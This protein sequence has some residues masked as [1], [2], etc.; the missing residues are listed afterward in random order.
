MA[1]NGTHAKN[2]KNGNRSN[3]GR[4]VRLHPKNGKP[5][6]PAI[7]PS[8]VAIGEMVPQ[9][10]GG[11]L[12]RGGPNKGGTGRPPDAFR[13]L[14]RELASGEKTIESVIKILGD[15][16]HSQFVAALRWATEHGYGKAIQP[17]E[18]SG[19]ISLEQILAASHER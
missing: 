4:A 2:G 8:S 5:L 15:P 1:S 16:D 12:R 17:L 18:H 6:R 14:C 11:A 9:E 13:E 7:D 10:H 19:A 3:G